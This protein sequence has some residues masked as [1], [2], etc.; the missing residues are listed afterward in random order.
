M[1]SFGAVCE[2]DHLTLT[3]NET[4]ALSFLKDF[5]SAYKE[6]NKTPA[7][8]TINLARLEQI[9][10]VGLGMLLSLRNYFGAEMPITLVR[11]GTAVR[12]TMDL[13]GFARY[14]AI[15]PQQDV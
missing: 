4:L 3:I 8:V 5:Y 15:E 2:D 14:F 13:I 7:R 9:D 10:L 6:L 12:G 1:D 11:A